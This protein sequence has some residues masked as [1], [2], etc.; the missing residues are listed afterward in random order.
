MKWGKFEFLCSISQLEKIR[1]IS[2]SCDGLWH[3]NIAVGSLNHGAVGTA[4]LM[5]LKAVASFALIRSLRC[6]F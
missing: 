4:R 5:S 2:Y 1:H 3:T 6:L